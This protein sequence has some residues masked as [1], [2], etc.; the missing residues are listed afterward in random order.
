[1]RIVTCVVLGLSLAASSAMPAASA[2]YGFAGRPFVRPHAG[3]VHVGPQ[4]AHPGHRNGRN[5]NF[6]TG[7][8]GYLGYPSV[9][10]EDGAGRAVQSQVFAPRTNVSYWPPRVGQ[11]DIGY[12]TQ[13]AIYNV[14]HELAK[15]PSFLP[16]P[17]K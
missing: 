16:G 10:G 17:S 5:N 12:V 4:A 14:A 1:M 8:G 15:R 7:Y 11:G 3:V 2:G 9:V 6:A 13:P